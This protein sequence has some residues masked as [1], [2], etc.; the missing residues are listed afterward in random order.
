MC[1]IAGFAPVP[2]RPLQ[3]AGTLA[4]M[5]AALAH[6]GPDADT[7]LLDR[8]FGLG[9]R[10]LAIIDRA[11]GDNPLE[12]PDRQAALVF[13]GE[14]Y[15]HRA[16]RREL[17]AAGARPLSGSDGEVILHGYLAW[18]L[19]PM[20]ARLRGMFAFAL[21]DRRERTLHLARDPFGIKPL[22]YAET[23]DALL[24]GSE[25]KA[26]LA[27][28]PERP[29]VS[30][31][32][33]AQYAALGYALAP[34]T[35]YR[36]V[37]C[38]PAGHRASWQAGRLRVARH[39][40]LQFTPGTVAADPERL[41]RALCTAVESHL[42]SEVPLGAFLSGGLDSSAVVRAMCA[43]GDGPVDAVVV[44]IEAGGLDERP[45]ART[46]AASLPQVRLHEAVAGVDLAALLPRIAWHHDGPFADSSAAATWLVCKAARRQVTVALSGDGGDENFAGYR[47]TRYDLLED[48]VRRLLPGRLGRRLAGSLGRA[49]PRSP[50]L[51]QPLRA[52]TF[53]ANVAEDWLG[54]YIRSLARIDQA[55]VRRLIRPELLPEAPLRAAFEP[56]AQAVAGLDP[57]SR[58]LA[59]DFATWLPDDI[60]AKV[61]RMS[62]AHGLEVRVP[63]LDTDFVAY[64]AGLP[65]HAKLRHGQ[66]KRLLRQALRS[67]L[68]AA[69]LARRK[70][71]FHLPVGTWL[72]GPLRPL[73]ERLTGRPAGGIADYLE[74]TFLARC[75]QEHLAGQRDRTTVL[76]FALM[77]DA[78]L[79]AETAAA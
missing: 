27:A 21:Y 5:T 77:L 4:R 49:W 26:I 50:R 15:N 6:R 44:G 52:G 20:L 41:W 53:L 17:E 61:D 35:I 38:L 7:M 55:T 59:M 28:L 42:M 2:D 60:L 22:F 37:L 75:A 24:F 56:Q 31:D 76:W 43:V 34:A 78:F 40:Q 30:P 45:Y 69:V 11:G 71:G 36:G 14:I 70:Q 25:I 12:D 46:V 18:G 33:L 66:G 29:A 39:H 47:R 74:P 58:V 19:E 57:L 72:K 68:P 3:D 16:L 79:A 64:A 51:P 23:R 48:R 62:M 32:G 67:R 63:F 65:N 9:H 13:N 73:L 8:G 10:R 1:G 54:A